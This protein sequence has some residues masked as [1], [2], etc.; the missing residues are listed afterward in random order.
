[1]RKLFHLFGR[2]RREREI[3]AELQ[4]YLDA[5]MAEKQRAGMAPAE[6]ERAA[7]I[8]FGGMAQVKEA[9]RESHFGAWIDPLFQDVRYGA[10]MLGR[11]NGFLAVA[12][13][14]LAL[15]IGANTALF[16]VTRAFLLRDLPYRDPDRLVNVYEIWPH[17]A[18][19]KN[20]V[21]I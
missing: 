18:Q 12:T 19:P 6:A 5:L 15:G 2:A 14:T 3:D 10:R 20:S 16:S 9:V 17:E 7:R 11:S 21:T 8:E 13:L 1:M 4:S